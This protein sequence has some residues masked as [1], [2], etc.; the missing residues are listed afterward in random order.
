MQLAVPR[1][2]S[3]ANRRTAVTSRN[4]F[5]CAEI[6]KHASAV[7]WCVTT[8]SRAGASSSVQRAQLQAAHSFARDF[9]SDH[10]WGSLPLTPALPDSHLHIGYAC[11]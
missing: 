11:P 8:F 9:I 2:V 6:I 1:R 5:M 7:A 3:A 10:S 4:Q